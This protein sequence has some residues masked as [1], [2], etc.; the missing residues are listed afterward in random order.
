MFILHSE[1]TVLFKIIKMMHFH[2]KLEYNHLAC[3]TGSG[4]EQPPKVQ[5]T[6]LHK[7]PSLQEKWYTHT[8]RNVYPCVEWQISGEG[9]SHSPS[10]QNTYKE[11]HHHLQT[12]GEAELAFWSQTSHPGHSL[13]TGADVLAS[14]N[15]VIH[16]SHWRLQG[17]SHWKTEGKPSLTQTNQVPSPLL[18][19]LSTQWLTKKLNEITTSDWLVLSP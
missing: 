3:C 18:Q 10:P 9:H 12:L 19:M 13:Q 7:H 8:D 14:Q 17:R 1:K 11:L 6:S 2:K 5:T 15:P 16:Q 4:A